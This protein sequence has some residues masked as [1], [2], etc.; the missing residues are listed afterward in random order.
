MNLQTDA[1]VTKGQAKLSE[2]RAARRA[3][4]SAALH[5]LRPAQHVAQAEE[6][7]RQAVRGT[8]VPSFLT[9]AETATLLRTSRKAIYAMAERGQLPGATRIGR[10]LLIRSDILLDWLDHKAAPS[11]KER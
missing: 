8:D 3:E 4:R 11:L 10:R 9:A 5:F 6:A 1:S 2:P 7:F